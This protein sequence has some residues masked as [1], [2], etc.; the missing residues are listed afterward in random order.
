M[1]EQLWGTLFN[2]VGDG[3]YGALTVG[4]WFL[5][6]Y[7]NIVMYGIVAVLFVVGM[8]VDLPERRRDEK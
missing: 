2:L 7:A 4:G 5:M 8:L 3:G 1:I 6:K